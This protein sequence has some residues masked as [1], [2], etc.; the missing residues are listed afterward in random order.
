MTSQ[1]SENRFSADVSGGARPLYNADTDTMDLVERGDESRYYWQGFSTQLVK[2]DVDPQLKSI[3]LSV[4]VNKG[5][6][7]GT[8]PMIA[9]GKVRA[10]YS[11]VREGNQAEAYVS[12]S[13]QMTLTVVPSTGDKR[14]EGIVLFKGEGNA[15]SVNITNG[16]FSFN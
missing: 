9:D 8:Y 1:K 3:N 4:F 15:K 7:A 2:S 5:V 11:L 13:G 6:E 16:V 10:V 12:V 14:L